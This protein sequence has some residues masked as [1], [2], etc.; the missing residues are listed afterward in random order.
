MGN[1]LCRGDKHEGT[2]QSQFSLIDKHLCDLIMEKVIV[3]AVFLERL[4]SARSQKTD[5]TYFAK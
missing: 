2:D 5:I 4:S 3:L 1:E